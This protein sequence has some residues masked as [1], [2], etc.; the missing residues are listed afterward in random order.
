[1][2]KKEL[3]LENL[4]VGQT[5]K[6]ANDY[7]Q[8]AADDIEKR[9]GKGKRKIVITLT[10]WDKDGVIDTN[11]KMDLILP[12]VHEPITHHT[13]IVVKKDKSGQYF[14]EAAEAEPEDRPKLK[15]V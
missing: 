4:L 10:M 15:S 9:P 6:D 13:Q 11:F 3:K 14:F 2:A 8:K 7:I 12:R 5:I 1:M